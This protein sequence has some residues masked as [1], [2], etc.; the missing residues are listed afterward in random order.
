MKNFSH[1]WSRIAI[2]WHH[3]MNFGSV[4]LIVSAIVGFFQESI[5]SAQILVYLLV[6]SLNITMSYY[7]GYLKF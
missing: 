2:I 7:K 5:P 3:M 1:L 6:G 4:T